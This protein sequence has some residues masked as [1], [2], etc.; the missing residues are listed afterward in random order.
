MSPMEPARRSFLSGLA[1]ALGGAVGE[2]RAAPVPAAGLRWAMVVD[3]ARCIGCQAC[4]V[5]CIMENAVPQDSLRTIVSTYEVREG[6]SA[7]MVMLPRLCNHCA[8]PPCIPVCPV[9]ATWQQAD[10][11]VVVNGDACVGCAFCARPSPSAA[12]FINHKPKK[13]ERSPFCP[14]RGGAGLRPA[15]VESGVGGARLFGDLHDPGS[16]V[17]R[18][19]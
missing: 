1:A 2:A 14:H 9:G 12:R 3:V 8:D 16:I 19:L 15:C 11:I 7:A 4:T 13:A 10:G 18:L 6:D 17:S 5:S